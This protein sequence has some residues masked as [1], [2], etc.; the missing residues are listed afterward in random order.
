MLQMFFHTA[1][2]RVKEC[3]HKNFEGGGGELE[4]PIKRTLS[5][6]T[7][8]CLALFKIGKRTNH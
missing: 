8:V 4:S 7:C 3:L 6:K 2:Q 1:T 5:N